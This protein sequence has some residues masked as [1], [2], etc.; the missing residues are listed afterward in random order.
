MDKENIRKRVLQALALNRRPGFHYSGWYA[1]LRFHEMPRG[2]SKATASGAAYCTDRDGQVNMGLVAMVADMALAGAIRKELTPSS[3]LA[4]ASMTLQFTGAPRVGDLEALGDFEGFFEGA[5]ARPGMSRVVVTAGGTDIAHGHAAFVPLEAPKGVTLAPIPGPG[6]AMDASPLDEKTLDRHEREVLRFADAA[7]ARG[8]A[9]FVRHFFGYAPHRVAHGASCVMKNG[10]HVANRVGH[11]QGGL[12]M[13]LAM[14][15]AACALPAHWACTG[16]HACF[17]SPGQGAKLRA[18]SR[19]LHHGLM[20]A[21]VRTEILGP[22]RR[23]VL[24]ATTTHARLIHNPE[25]A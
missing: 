5:V 21:V 1:D 16:I 6:E 18:R 15:T 10:M 19:V 8:E 20:T 12:L 9:D 13:G 25:S 4:T 17:T 7:L 3:R 2:R 22:G 14:E 23:R 24:E 11:V